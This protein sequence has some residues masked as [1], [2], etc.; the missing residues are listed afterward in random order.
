MKKTMFLIGVV[1]LY[2]DI[3]KLFTK[4]YYLVGLPLFVLFCV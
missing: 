1:Y 2:I 4:H 3:H